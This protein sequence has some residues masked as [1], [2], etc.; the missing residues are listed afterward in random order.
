MVAEYEALASC[1][2]RDGAPDLATA[3]GAEGP[4]RFVMK[5]RF[6]YS[7]A[8]TVTRTFGVCTA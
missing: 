6:A 2:F 1:P 8:Q 7:L 4:E 5:I 3:M